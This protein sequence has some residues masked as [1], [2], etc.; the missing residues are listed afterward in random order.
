MAREIVNVQAAIIK[1]QAENRNGE[2]GEELCSAAMA[3]SA[4]TAATAARVSI[5]FSSSFSSLSCRLPFSSSCHLQRA[6]KTLFCA[7]NPTNFRPS[8]TWKQAKLEKEKECVC[9]CVCH[10]HTHT[11]T[12]TQPHSHTDTQT[13]RHTHTQTHTHRH[14]HTYKKHAPTKKTNVATKSQAKSKAHSRR[15]RRSQY[16]NVVALPNILIADKRCFCR[17][18]LVAALQGLLFLLPALFLLRRFLCLEAKQCKT[19]HKGKETER[20]TARNEFWCLLQQETDPA[21]HQDT[22]CSQRAPSSPIP[23]CVLVVVIFVVATLSYLGDSVVWPPFLVANQPNSSSTNVNFVSPSSSCSF[24]SPSTLFCFVPFFLQYRV[25]PGYSF[26]NTQNTST[27]T[28]KKK[29]KQKKKM[30][31]KTKQ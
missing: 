7:R 14:T 31:G 1:E 2:K 8:R 28:H 17:R 9:V 25:K 24:E 15:I 30:G 12:A 13:H 27:H 20:N 4:A 21:L 18:H 5:T 29:K 6:M 23:W 26:T 11:H 10:T 16:L 3:A 19:N 22:C